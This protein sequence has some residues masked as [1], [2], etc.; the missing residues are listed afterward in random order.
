[1]ATNEAY[2][3]LTYSFLKM[4]PNFTQQFNQAFNKTEL[5]KFS[6]PFKMFGKICFFLEN[7]SG[8]LIRT[9]TRRLRRIWGMDV[10]PRCYA[11][12]RCTR[13]P[14]RSTCGRDGG[15]R[16]CKRGSP[17]RSSPRSRRY[18]FAGSGNVLQKKIKAWEPLNRIRIYILSRIL[19]PLFK[20]AI[21]TIY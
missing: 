17:W 15:P 18:M 10:N 16:S 11:A 4:P 20:G 12:T 3:F 9:Y 19:K 21:Y 5:V 8:K 1:M 6:G 14:R 13:P 7:L 2:D